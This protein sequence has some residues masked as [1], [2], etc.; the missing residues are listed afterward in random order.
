MTA[1]N[2][3]DQF[4]G[5]ELGPLSQGVLFQGVSTAASVGYSTNLSAVG[6]VQ[7]DNSLMLVSN[8]RWYPFSRV[9][10]VKSASGEF[11]DIPTSDLKAISEVTKGQVAKKVN[12]Y[13]GFL[14]MIDFEGKK[15]LILAKEV[16]IHMFYEYD[17]VLQTCSIK[18]ID[19][20]DGSVHEALS[21]QLNELVGQNGYFTFKTNITQR[22]TASTH[23]QKYNHQMFWA[24]ACFFE[25]VKKCSVSKD[26]DLHFTLVAI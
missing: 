17:P 26:W 5:K 4:I 1:V 3:G 22:L 13:S 25:Q 16:S 7:G 19:L 11:N 15:Y 20:A 23:K 24:G 14:G 9:L 8:P 10:I 2:Q 21:S 18:A 12:Y 6:V